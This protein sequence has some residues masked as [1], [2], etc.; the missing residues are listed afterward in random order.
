VHYRFDVLNGFSLFG[1]FYRFD[2]LN[3]LQRLGFS[4]SLDRL[5]V[6]CWLGVVLRLGMDLVRRFGGSLG[7]GPFGWEDFVWHVILFGQRAE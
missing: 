5:S 7:F 1:V 3:V 4:S 6:L 2:V